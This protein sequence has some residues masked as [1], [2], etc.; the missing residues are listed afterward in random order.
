VLPQ[1]AALAT[2]CPA[3]ELDVATAPAAIDHRR[4]GTAIFVTV[5][6]SAVIFIDAFA[7][8]SIVELRDVVAERGGSVHLAAVPARIAW[9]FELA[10]LTELLSSTAPARKPGRRLAGG[11]GG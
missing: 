5:D 8:G 1:P 2:L 9:V 11:S 4:L 3:G 6:M 10:G 7:L